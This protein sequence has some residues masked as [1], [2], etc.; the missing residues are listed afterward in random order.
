MGG[1]AEI[2]M[3]HTVTEVIWNT[4]HYQS[5]FHKLHM[6]NLLSKIVSIISILYL[7]VKIATNP[8]TFWLYGKQLIHSYVPSLILNLIFPSK[9]TLD[10]ENIWKYFSHTQ[11]KK[12]TA[13]MKNAWLNS[14]I[15]ICLNVCVSLFMGK[16]KKD[17]DMFT[18]TFENF[19]EILQFWS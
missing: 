4:K 17:S 6:W 3:K 7:H 15:P 11:E 5:T 8:L 14:Q 19:I 2:I 1:G 12:V 16:I 13:Y 10:H 18:F 9:N